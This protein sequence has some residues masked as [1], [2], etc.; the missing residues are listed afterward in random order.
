VDAQDVLRLLAE[1]IQRVVIDFFVVPEGGIFDVCWSLQGAGF[2][3]RSGIL[4]LGEPAP[5]P[6]S[7]FAPALAEALQRLPGFDHNAY[8]R[9]RQAIEARDGS[10]LAFV[11]WERPTAP[12]ERGEAPGG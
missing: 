6:T 11:C 9:A 8:R 2:E 5:E 7:G 12:T 1:Q 3:F 10:V 4:L